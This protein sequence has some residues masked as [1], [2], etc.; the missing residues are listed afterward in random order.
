MELNLKWPEHEADLSPLSSGDIKNDRSCTSI[1][2]ICS[3][4]VPRCNLHVLH[5]PVRLMKG[6]P[7][8]LW[9]SNCSIYR[10]HSLQTCAGVLTLKCGGHRMPLHCVRESSNE[11]SEPRTERRSI[12]YQDL[13]LHCCCYAGHSGLES[14]S[15]RSWFSSDYSGTSASLH[16]YSS[17]IRR[18]PVVGCYVIT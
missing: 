11:T 15:W 9:C 4:D 1:A 6:L 2:P 3:Y 17:C 16:M 5:F 18:N 10:Q 8:H 13:V 7:S 14:W 12:T